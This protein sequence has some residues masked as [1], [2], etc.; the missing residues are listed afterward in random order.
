VSSER[1]NRHL[2]T[3]EG[4]LC[5]VLFLQQQKC[6]LPFTFSQSFLSM[7]AVLSILWSFCFECGFFFFFFL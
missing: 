2:E 6:N 7:S 5:I 3:Q 1:W 4:E